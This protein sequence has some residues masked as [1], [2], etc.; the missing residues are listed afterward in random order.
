MTA[1]MIDKMSMVAPDDTAAPKSWN[2]IPTN[3]NQDALL[4]ALRRLGVITGEAR[5]VNALLAAGHKYP[6]KE[7]DAAMSKASVSIEDRFRLKAAM[8]RMGIL[9]N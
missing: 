4:G 5:V 8:G 2:Y 3:L 9:G 1:G 7:V 6:V